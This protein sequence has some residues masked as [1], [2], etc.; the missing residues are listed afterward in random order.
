MVII[1]KVTQKQTKT[2]ST[3]SKASSSSTTAEDK[4]VTSARTMSVMEG[5]LHHKKKTQQWLKSHGRDL[6][7]LFDVAPIARAIHRN[8]ANFFK[9]NSIGKKP[10]VSSEA[11]AVCCSFL[12]SAMVQLANEAR[13]QTWARGKKKLDESDVATA[14]LAYE[15]PLGYKGNEEL[16]RANCPR[17]AEFV[18]TKCVT[19][20]QTRTARKKKSEEGE[21]KSTPVEEEKKTQKKKKMTTP[22]EEEMEQD[23]EEE[24]QS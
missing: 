14:L 18:E 13:M 6:N 4:K 7:R 11:V 8:A 16:L 1:R 20:T 23:E 17:Y 22:V 10:R 21:K 5:A 15:A 9:E 2:A 24:E 19:I 3:K 12:S